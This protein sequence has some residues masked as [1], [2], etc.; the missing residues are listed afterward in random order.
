[1][2]LADHVRLTP[3]KP[4]MIVPGRGEVTFAQ[5]EARSNQLAHLLYDRG[6]RRGDHI[7]V[8]MENHLMFMDAVWA[9]FRSGLQ[10]TAINRYLPAEEAAYIASDCE[11]RALITSREETSI[12]RPERWGTPLTVVV[13]WRSHQ[14]A[15]RSQAS[16][17][18]R[19]LC[20][21]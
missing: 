14:A 10:V 5:L 18:L 17:T 1:M 2:Y 20:P 11:A 16:R 13:A 21:Q 8:Y 15:R 3:D 12:S 4:A 7:A 6:L 19:T 9:A